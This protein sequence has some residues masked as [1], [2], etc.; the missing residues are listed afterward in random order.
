MPALKLA[1]PPIGSA[2]AACGCRVTFE[3]TRTGKRIPID[4]TPS[5][6]GAYELRDGVLVVVADEP[7]LELGAKGVT[8]ERFDA[9]ADT[10]LAGKTVQP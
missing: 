2:C 9:H 4:V 10:C 8:G 5:K 1:L 6:D 3:T 7:Q